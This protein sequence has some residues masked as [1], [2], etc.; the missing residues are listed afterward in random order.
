MPALVKREEMAPP[1]LHIICGGGTGSHLLRNLH[2]RGYHLSVGPLSELDD[3][4]Q[5]ARSLGVEFAQVPTDGRPETDS[6]AHAR[7]LLVAADAVILTPF[8]VGKGNLASLALA[9][10]LSPQ[11]PLYLVLGGE[12]ARRDYSGGEAARLYALLRARAAAVPR[13]TSD[14]LPMLAGRF[15]LD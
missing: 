10:E 14:L 6:L 7:K 4:A 9:L 2:A 8:A 1:R 12:F 5:T 13:T 11:T 15:P 3:D